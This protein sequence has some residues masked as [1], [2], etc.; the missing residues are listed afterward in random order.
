MST[1]RLSLTPLTP[2]HVGSGETL[3][4]YQYAL[5]NDRVYVLSLPRLLEH[6]EPQEQTAYLAAIS[7]GPLAARHHVARLV[8]RGL[9]LKA[10]SAWTARA[11]RGFQAYVTQRLEEAH[12]QAE[13]EVRTLPRSPLGA[14]LPGSSLKGA[15]RTA[16]L[17]AQLEKELEYDPD[18]AEG[19]YDLVYAHRE[20]T[21]Q[22][23]RGWVRPPRKRNGWVSVN[24]A[25]EA[26]VFKNLN[27]RKRPNQGADPL[28][29]VAFTDSE[30]LPETTF[31]KIAVQGTRENPSGPT[32]IHLL[33]EAWVEGSVEVTLRIH[34]AFQDRS[35][36]RHAVKPRLQDIA[37]DAF[38]RYAYLAE[39]EY[40]EYEERGWREAT[41]AMKRVLDAVDACLDGNGKLRQPYR[42]PLRLGFGS[43]DSTLRLA[44]FLKDYRSPVSRKLAE[45]QPLG[46]VLVEVLE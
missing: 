38:N 37:I 24:Q 1:H 2:V 43:G 17:A 42:F 30:P 12:P 9:D 13:L 20:W 27:Q 18:Q 11:S 34:E 22:P 32:G 33:A 6:L 15:V 44:E 26:H 39:Q 3:E 8:A 19:R 45:D 31:L 25:F 10:V 29:T 7:E 28:R 36:Y 5:V 14:Y 21:H 35:I 16:L 23:G 40:A 46:W 41:S 4:P